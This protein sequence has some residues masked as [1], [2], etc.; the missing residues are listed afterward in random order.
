MLETTKLCDLHSTRKNGATII[1]GFGS[2]VYEI[3]LCPSHT[4]ELTGLM[5][6][7]IA[8]AH[9]TP[10]SMAVSPA[11]NGKRNS[12]SRTTSK[13]IR[14]WAIDEGIECGQNGRLPERVIKLYQTRNGKG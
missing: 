7:L 2:D 3:E 8:N 14:Q 6:G 13:R 1:F 10:M 9:K 5:S 4:K 12:V 11:K